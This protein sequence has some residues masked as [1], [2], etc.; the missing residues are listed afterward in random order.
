[1]CALIADLYNEASDTVHVDF[2]LILA[3]KLSEPPALSSA[4][5]RVRPTTATMIQEHG[6]AGVL[7]AERAC[8]GNAIGLRDRWR[9]D[10]T[11]CSNHLY[12]CWLRPGETQPFDNHYPINANIIA[13]W[14][15]DIDD[16][17]SDI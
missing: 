5:T 11:H 3:E 14:A 8:S 17:K 9:C 12:C 4:A 2:D 13:M 16:R 6:I 7:A 1:L 15:R 10:D